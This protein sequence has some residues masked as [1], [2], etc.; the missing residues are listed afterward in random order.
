MDAYDR[1]TKL[2]KNLADIVTIYVRGRK[3]FRPT[4]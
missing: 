2:E 4:T 1:R 3:L